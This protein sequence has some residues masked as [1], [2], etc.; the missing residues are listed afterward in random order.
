MR[1][2]WEAIRPKLDTLVINKCEHE[3]VKACIFC[4]PQR[5]TT[6]YGFLWADWALPSSS[7]NTRHNKFMEVVLD[8]TLV[9]MAAGDG[10]TTIGKECC[11]QAV[12]RGDRTALM[13]LDAL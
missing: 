3:E 6:L 2:S 5:R 4:K 7:Q 11:L 9:V 10:H 12:G 8:N 13:Q 1:E